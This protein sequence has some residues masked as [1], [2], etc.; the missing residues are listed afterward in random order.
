MTVIKFVPTPADQFG[1]VALMHIHFLLMDLALTLMNAQL[2]HTTASSAV[3]M[4]MEDF[5]VN[6]IQATDSTLMELLAA[7]VSIICCVPYFF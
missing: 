5:Y 4:S 2:V 6:V 7:P 3:S 1:A